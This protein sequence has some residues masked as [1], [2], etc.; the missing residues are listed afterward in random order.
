[1]TED[2]AGL[3]GSKRKYLRGLAHGLKPLVQVGKGG[4]TP[5]L[6]AAVNGA[7]DE[8]E[9]IKVKFVDFKEEKK[10]LSAEI[11]RKTKSERVGMIGNVAVFYRQH[12][13]PEKRKI[14]IP[15]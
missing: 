6:L 10:E 2:K 3:A 14:R 11:G 8:H 15:A 4:V 7:L 9:L 1:M 12:A 13:D 5:A